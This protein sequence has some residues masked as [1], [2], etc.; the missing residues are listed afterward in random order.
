MSLHWPKSDFFFVAPMRLRSVFFHSTNTNHI[1]DLFNSDTDLWIKAQVAEQNVV[2]HTQLQQVYLAADKW[3]DLHKRHLCSRHEIT[4]YCSKTLYCIITL[5]AGTE[6]VGVCVRL[7]SS[8]WLNSALT[9]DSGSSCYSPVS[10][11]F[12]ISSPELC[13]VIN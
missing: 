9:T 11:L 2:D 1:S 8:L 7:Q 4:R 3:A 13:E 10:F 5:T 12:P 6:G